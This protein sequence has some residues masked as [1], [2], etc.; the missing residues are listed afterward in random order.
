MK[1]NSKPSVEDISDV[2]YSIMKEAVPEKYT[3]I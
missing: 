3:A 1:Q 2:I